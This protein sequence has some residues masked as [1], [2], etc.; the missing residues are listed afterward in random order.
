MGCGLSRYPYGEA[1]RYTN[2]ASP[3]DVGPLVKHSF[4]AHHQIQQLSKKVHRNFQYRQK[5]GALLDLASQP[6]WR[7]L[8]YSDQLQKQPHAP[9]FWQ[10][11]RLPS[12]AASVSSLSL[13]ISS[14]LQRPASLPIEFIYLSF[15]LQTLSFPQV[16]TNS[17]HTCTHSVNGGTW[18]SAGTAP[19]GIRSG[20]ASCTGLPCLMI[21]SQV[22]PKPLQAHIIAHHSIVH[23]LWMT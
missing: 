6:A 15:K 22:H 3:F 21:G 1:L 18:C 19:A 5:P 20:A 8:C 13:P 16:Q 2:H 9:Q 12:K 10:T 4:K 11:F 14:S 23:L 7:G 17:T